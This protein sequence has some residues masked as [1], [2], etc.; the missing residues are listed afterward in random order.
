M[1][2]T[3][4]AAELPTVPSAARIYSYTLGGSHYYPVDQAAA[5][6]M[7]T[8]VP[9]TPKWVRMLRAFL[10]QAARRLWHE[11]FRHFVDFASG[12]PSEDHIHHVLP[13][14]KVVYSDSDPATVALAQQLVGHLPNVLYRQHD[15]REAR[16]LLEAAQVQTFL[17]G[18]RRVAFG[19]SGITVFLKPDEIS[20][21]FHDLYVW[22]APGARLYVT[23]ETKLPGMMTPQM[24]QF[25]DMFRQAGSPFYLYSVE[26]CI[27]LSQP[28]Q[29]PAQ[30]LQPLSEFLALPADTISEADREGVGLEFYAAILEKPAR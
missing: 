19:L 16:T 12:L 27:A 5:E 30:G 20:Q 8:L 28:W 13:E 7:F 24:E 26:E 2:T 11:G 18:E 9:S 3:I 15:V 21:L 22:A 14:A 1:Q 23:Y 6:Y 17:G 4:P 10:Q 25:L 29:L